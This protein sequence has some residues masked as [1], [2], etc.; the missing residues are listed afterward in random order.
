LSENETHPVLRNAYIGARVTLYYNNS[1]TDQGTVTYLDN[2]WVELTKDNSE[3]L[4]VPTTAVRLIKLMEAS[5][6]QTD[7]EILL[8][9]FEGAPQ[10]EAK[11][12]TD[13]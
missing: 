13:E 8:R 11:R 9:P 6:R 12:E 1:Y 3:R 4:L 7:S 5:R 10:I 2:A